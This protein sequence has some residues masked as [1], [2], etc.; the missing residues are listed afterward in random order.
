MTLQIV[1]MDDSLTEVELGEE[2][3]L[4][5]HHTPTGLTVTHDEVGTV[6]RWPWATVKSYTVIPAEDPITVDPDTCT[7]TAAMDAYQRGID[8]GNRSVLLCRREDRQ[9]GAVTVGDSRVPAA[10]VLDSIR[11]RGTREAEAMW[12]LL[13][14][15]DLEMLTWLVADLDMRAAHPVARGDVGPATVTDPHRV[16]LCW[17]DGQNHGRVSVFPNRSPVGPMISRV[18]AGEDLGKVAFDYGIPRHQLA[19]L[20]RLTEELR[21]TLDKD[22]GVGDASTDAKQRDF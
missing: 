21:A 16:Q 7:N 19:V 12:P 9:G 13:T 2:G 4:T 8:D 10:A 6:T 3:A 17:V 18:L 1:H 14:A 20:V 15:Q 5:W 22:L 11:A